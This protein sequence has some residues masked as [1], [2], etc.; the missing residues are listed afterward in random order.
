MMWRGYDW[1]LF[2]ETRIHTEYHT[3]KCT[4]CRGLQKEE[5]CLDLAFK[6]STMKNTKTWTERPI[7]ASQFPGIG[8]GPF[9]VLF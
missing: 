9:L 1:K 2:Q 4:D 8:F 3:M 5:E 6:K 7:E